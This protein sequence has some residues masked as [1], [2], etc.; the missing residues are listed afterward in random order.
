MGRPDQSLRGLVREKLR[1]LPKRLH[2]YH[3]DAYQRCLPYLEILR[4]LQNHRN[5]QEA[6]NATTRREYKLPTST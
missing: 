1:L 5:A 3:Y 2:E 4:C 6:L